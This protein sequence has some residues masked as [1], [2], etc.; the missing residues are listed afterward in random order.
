MTGSS[1]AGLV[2][3]WVD[4][5]TRGL[6][7]DARTVRRD[8]IDDDLWCQHEEA[9]ALGRSAHSLDAALFIRLVFGI[10]A[11][12]SWRLA[13]RRSPTPPSLDR[14]SSMS[15]RTLGMLAIVAGGSPMVLGILPYAMGD[16]VWASGI[17]LVLVFALFG[18][19]FAFPAAALGLAW[20]FQDRLGPL[21]AVGAILV[22]LG[23]V[24][25]ILVPTVGFVAHPVGSAM[26]MW[27]LARIGVLSRR[28]AIGQL[29]AVILAIGLGLVPA[30]LGP[31]QTSIPPIAIGVALYAYLLSWIAI[32][33]SLI[34]RVPQALVT[35]A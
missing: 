34:R 29:V 8:E 23:S 14:S 24:L 35:S 15:T 16:A 3:R 11:D 9:A 31:G 33:V 22:T 30:L 26:L 10:P 17:G 12:L 5:Y 18:S 28:L 2:R 4:L 21:G 6:P 32:G 13:Y 1:V 27:D 19:F 20:R 25:I 7:A